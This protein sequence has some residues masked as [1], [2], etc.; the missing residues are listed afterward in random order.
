MSTAVA[1]AAPV[2][3]AAINP[4]IV[5]FAVVIPTFMEVL[6]T[7]IANVALR[8]IAG[9]LSAAVTDSEWVITSYLAANATVLPISGWLATRLGRRNYFLGSIAVFTIASALCG[10]ATSLE[11]LIFFR[12]L[13]G[14]A[15]GG[16]QPS[17]QAILLDAF[18]PAKQGAAMTLFGMAALIAPVVGPTLG[19]YLTVNYDWRWIFYINVPIGIFGL[20]AAAAVLQDPDYL[21]Q[22]R[23]DMKKSGFRFDTIGL[24]ALALTLSSW[25]IL[26][27]KGQEWDWFGD[28]F[29][30]VQ[31]LAACFVGGL[32]FFIWHELRIAA[33]VVN[34]RPLAERNFAAS[35]IICFS[36]YAVLYAASTT[37]PALLQALFGYDALASGIVMSPSGLFAIMA[38]MTVGAI[39]GRGIDARW[40]IAIGLLLMAAGCYWMAIMNLDISPWQVVW[41]RVVMIMGLSTLF[42]PLNVA[43]Y[44]YTPRDMRAAAVG[45]FALLRNEGGSVGTSL[46]QTMEVRREQFHTSRIGEFLDPLNPTVNEF[47]NQGEQFYLQFTGDPVGS[48]QM[49]L[50]TLANLRQEQAAALSY[51]DDFYLFAMLALSLLLLLPLMKRSVPGKGVQ[52]HAE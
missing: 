4:W 25:E 20:L 32:G 29:W 2:Q 42:A 30:R 50:Q 33:P 41:P 31:V 3:R 6:D 51:F 52:I 15:G 14:L 46:A 16:L 21:K 17:S 26:L 49:A 48:R 28:P 35:C 19:G 40:F 44:L 7:T 37:L 10:A 45:L 5:A 23:A 47:L 36:A 43:A 12:I 38:I 9:G 27:S 18:P 13:Q 24:G 22:E 39:L 11:E 34:L 1:T 8:Y